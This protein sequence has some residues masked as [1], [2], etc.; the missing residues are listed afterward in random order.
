MD[1]YMNEKNE[2]ENRDKS[3]TQID[4]SEDMTAWKRKT[5]LFLSSQAL[6]LF[7][8][9][10][11]QYAITWYIT[12]KTQSG[13]MMTIAIICGFLPTF[14]LSPFAGVWADRFN[15]KHLIIISDSFIAISTLVLA[16]LFML[17]YQATWLLFAAMS[18]RA[19]GSGIQSPAVSAIIPQIV[20]KKHL[21]RI[22][23]LNSSVHSFVSLLSPLLSG[24][25]LSIAPIESV[26]F[27]DVVTAAIAVFFLSVF[28]H[29]PP[30]KKALQKTNTGY[31][32]DLKLGVKYIWKH[33]FIRLFFIFC[34]VFF[35]LAA[36]A[37]FLTPLQVTRKFGNNVLHLTA[38]EIAFSIGMLVGGLI[39]AAWQG[40]RNKIHTVAMA[41]FVFS[42]FTVVL[43]FIP[44]FPVYLIIMGILGLAMP[45]F[46]TPATVLFQQKVD[47]NYLGRVFGVL[48]M[49]TSSIMPLSMLLFGPLA[50]IIK[51]DWIIIASGSLI[52]VVGLI[53]FFSK[54]LIEEGETDSLLEST[55]PQQFN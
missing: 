33:D 11:V 46:N 38:I 55:A 16:L 47:P 2:A 45:F 20:P 25:L 19:I 8:S 50:D 35:F 15:R 1:D 54:V 7:G 13:I 14:F 31:F 26:F 4:V 51:V 27:I 28:L 52:F 10:L 30:H 24:A 32:S 17:G 29:V 5:S 3:K 34:A 23:A 42:L 22:N 39:M 6:S 40:F 18:L 12:I 49:L 43:G 48:G 41:G 37:C 53:V 9:S 44:V 36:P 21:S